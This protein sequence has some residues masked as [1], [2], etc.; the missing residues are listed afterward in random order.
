MTA[1]TSRPDR[2]LI[3]RLRKRLRMV[4]RQRDAAR[5]AAEQQRA[6]TQ[7]GQTAEYWRRQREREEGEVWEV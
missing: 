4:R 6:I 3:K 2:I 7:N 1:P 5:D